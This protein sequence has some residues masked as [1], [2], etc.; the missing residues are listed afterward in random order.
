MKNFK[1]VNVEKIEIA[2]KISNQEINMKK[3]W[4]AGEKILVEILQQ[5]ILDW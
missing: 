5:K 2:E 4:I 3:I 1:L